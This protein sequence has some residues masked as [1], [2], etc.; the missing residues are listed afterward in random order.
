MLYFIKPMEFT[1]AN[2]ETLMADF[3]INRGDSAIQNVTA[4]VNIFG[5]PPFSVADS[6]RFAFAGKQHTD[7][8]PKLLFNENVKRKTY[9]RQSFEIPNEFFKESLSA[10]KVT[11]TVFKSGKA[12]EYASGK[13]WRKG[14]EKI[15]QIIYW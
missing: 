11:I 6:V 2:K 9:T 13:K 12:T 8:K 10:E 7:A 4:N 5:T 15:Y 14:H 1:S 3:T